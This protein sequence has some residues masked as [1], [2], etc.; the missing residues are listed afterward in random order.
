MMGQWRVEVTPSEPRKEDRFLHVIQVG[1]RQRAEMSTAELIEEVDRCGVRIPAAN[2]TWEVL[3]Q[4][5]GTLGG[6]IR[7]CG[8][9]S[10]IDRALATD[11]QPQTGIMAR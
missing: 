6:C 7:R 9:A 1:D 10:T 8:P 4:T 5:S 2:E 3:F 11:V